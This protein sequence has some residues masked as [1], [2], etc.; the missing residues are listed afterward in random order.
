[1]I[2]YELPTSLHDPTHRSMALGR[3]IYGCDPRDFHRTMV[4]QIPRQWINL[5]E[6]SNYATKCQN[7]T[8]RTNSVEGE[9]TSTSAAFYGTSHHRW[10]GKELRKTRTSK[11]RC[12]GR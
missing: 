9:N 1:M 10:D 12:V 2:D 6:S 3:V 8:K 5:Q 7:L 4:V 11:L